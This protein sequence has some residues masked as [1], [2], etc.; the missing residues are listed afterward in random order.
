[1]KEMEKST[2]WASGKDWKDSPKIAFKTNDSAMGNPSSKSHKE[3][4]EGS[5][6]AAMRDDEWRNVNDN[7][8]K[9]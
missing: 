5:I 6:L 7:R 1:M 9:K 2:R 3:S 4:A 8:K